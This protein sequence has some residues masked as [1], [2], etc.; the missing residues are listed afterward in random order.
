MND[1]T[2]YNY[3]INP[4]YALMANYIRS[5]PTYHCPTDREMVKIGTGTYPRL[6]SYEL[7]AYAGWIEPW[8]QTWDYRMSSLFRIFRKTT[9]IPA[10]IPAGLIYTFMDVNPD[11]ICWPYFGMHM[12]RD[13]FFNFPNASHNRG[14]VV[15]FADSHVEYHKWMDPRTYNPVGVNWHQHDQPSPGNVDYFWLRD[16]TTI[17]N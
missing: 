10:K 7:N 9:D 12:D 13:S 1:N 11:S 15:T 3:V 5:V 8:N 2:N 14:G 4:A 16:R 17:H 6:R